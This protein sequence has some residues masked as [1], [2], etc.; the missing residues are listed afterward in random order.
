MCIGL[1]QR[2]PNDER[3]GER[4]PAG[5]RGYNQELSSLVK[6]VGSSIGLGNLMHEGVYAGLS[7]PSYETPHELQAIGL[8]GG[9]SV[10]MSTTPEVITASHCGMEVLGLSLITNICLRP[11]DMVT[12]IPS[13]EEVLAAT[14][15]RT[16]D[17]E[18]LVKKTLEAV[19]L[20]KFKETKA[21][22]YFV[23]ENNARKCPYLPS[24][25]TLNACCR[26]LGLVSVAAAVGALTSL[27]FVKYYKSN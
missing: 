11:G 24:S 3:F 16:K 19:D 21:H 27:A 2:G 23:K 22:Q 7:G 26:D 17:M 14:K 9:D 25:S 4:F 5:G 13:H 1:L 6:S 8:L 10:G 15:E 18:T 12:P 20:S